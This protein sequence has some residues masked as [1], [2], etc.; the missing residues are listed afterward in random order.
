MPRTRPVAGLT[1][2]TLTLAHSYAGL[3]DERGGFSATVT[4]TLTAP[5]HPTLRETIPLT[6]LHKS[7]KASHR[8][9]G[10]IGTT[11]RRSRR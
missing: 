9:K 8:H 10:R 4:V 2:L 7:R 6:F 11:R 3:A 5:G 1:T